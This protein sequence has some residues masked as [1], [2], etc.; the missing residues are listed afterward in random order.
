MSGAGDSG[1][2]GVAV[3]CPV[4][5]EDDD[6]ARPVVVDSFSKLVH[7][8]VDDGGVSVDEEAVNV[9]VDCFVCDSV[10]EGF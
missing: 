4:V 7:G 8:C 10:A 3:E 2:E 6:D 9:W 5:Y 1:C